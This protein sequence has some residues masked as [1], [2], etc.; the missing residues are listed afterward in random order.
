VLL[1]VLIYWVGQRTVKAAGTSL[2]VVF[3]SSFV[4]V[5]RKGA[6]GDI[7][8]NLLAVL[9]VGGMFGTYFGTKIGLRLAG[10]RIRSCFVYVVVIAVILVGAKLYMLTF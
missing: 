7:D 1:P 2:L 10:P 8:I 3:I 6:G 4:G 5:I 9:L